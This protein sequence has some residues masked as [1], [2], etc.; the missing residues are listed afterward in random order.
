MISTCGMRINIIILYKC[1]FPASVKRLFR[2]CFYLWPVIPAS[3]SNISF[4][5]CGGPCSY[6][7][8]TFI[9]RRRW[10]YWYSI[11]FGTCVGVY[12]YYLLPLLLYSFASIRFV[13]CMPISL[14]SF[15]L[16]N[17]NNRFPPNPC[18]LRY[19]K[20]TTENIETFL[21]KAVQKTYKNVADV[22]AKPCSRIALLKQIYL[23]EGRPSHKDMNAT[24]K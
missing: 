24:F 5:T 1:L 11:F 6:L 14:W 7:Y 16:P 20:T 4:G 13:I 9:W 2:T 12:L 3:N 18:L 22:K 19:S 8:T 21:T 15:F 23:F 17:W 10:A